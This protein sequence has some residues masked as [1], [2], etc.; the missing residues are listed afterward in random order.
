MTNR[1]RKRLIA[2]LLVAPLIIALPT[3]WPRLHEPGFVLRNLD[4]MLIFFAVPYA[5]AL[6]LGVQLLRRK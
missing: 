4:V 6:W 3:L 2:A 1:D 5:A